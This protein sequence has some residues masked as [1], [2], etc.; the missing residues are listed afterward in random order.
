MRLG[1]VGSK[2][3]GGGVGVGQ[4]PR[5]QVNVS[6]APVKTHVLL[7]CGATRPRINRRAW[8]YR[9]ILAG[10]ES[11]PCVSTEVA[12]PAGVR[13]PSWSRSAARCVR[14]NRLLIHA[15][16]RSRRPPPASVSPV[17]R[18]D[19]AR[20]SESAPQQPGDRWIHVNC[21]LVVGIACEGRFDRP[22]F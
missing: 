13:P 15:F 5:R 11:M 9:L 21:K 8:P 22:E 20:A 10:D 16:I 1:R 4:N 12:P 2:G 18:P 14:R 3:E 6:S 17:T 7:T 19:T